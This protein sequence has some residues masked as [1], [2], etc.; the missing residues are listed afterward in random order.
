MSRASDGR[1]LQVDG[2]AKGPL[3]ASVEARLRDAGA[4]TSEHRVSEWALLV[5]K[6][7][8]QR[9]HR[10]ADYDPA[11]LK[12]KR[13]APLIL[14]VGLQDGS[15]GCTSRMKCSSLAAATSW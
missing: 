10:H 14:L 7:G 15:R 8:C 3:C 9:Q 5:S 2:V 13:A 11:A 6:A 1:R 12:C 4:L